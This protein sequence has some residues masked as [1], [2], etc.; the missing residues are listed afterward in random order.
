MFVISVEGPKFTNKHLWS[1][2]KIVV[3][4]AAKDE[5]LAAFALLKEDLNIHE[6][7]DIVLLSNMVDGLVERLFIRAEATEEANPIP[8]IN[9]WEEAKIVRRRLLGWTG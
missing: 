4:K 6:E 1:T 7:E 2:H 9:S 8:V 5:A 3:A